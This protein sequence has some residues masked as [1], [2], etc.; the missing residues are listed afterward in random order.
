MTARQ[1][2]AQEQHSYIPTTEAYGQWC[3]KKGIEACSETVDESGTKAHW[4]GDRGAKTVLYYLHG[5]GFNAP[6]GPEYFN[7]LAEAI[8]FVNAKAREQ[9]GQGGDALAAL[10]LAYERAPMATYPYQLR[11]AAVGLNYLL[12]TLKVKPQNVILV[13]DSAGANLVLAVLGHILHPHPDASIPRITGSGDTGEALRFKA[14]L[15][16]APWIKFTFDAPSITR[17]ITTDM[18]SLGLCRRWAAAYMGSAPV[19][20][21]NQ[22]LTAP[23]GWWSQ[24]REVVPRLLNAGGSREILADDI[25]KLG[26]VLKRECVDVEVENI[27]TEEGHDTVILDRLAGFQGK[28]IGQEAVVQTW[29]GKVVVG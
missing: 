28:D 2:S 23:E 10:L 8:D 11:Q 6:A 22:P 17:N 9:D 14:V 25:V 24:M 16:L 1:T 19:D 15:L 13:G 21:Y 3:A 4:I 29:L 12:N 7:F 18:I 20:P 5:G 27:M 26:E